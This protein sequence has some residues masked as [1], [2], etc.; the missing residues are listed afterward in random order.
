MII[1]TIAV[2]AQTPA[3]PA[4]SLPRKLTLAEAED[5]LIRRNLLV[6]AARYQIDANRAQ[7]LISSYKPNPVVT[8]GIEQLTFFSPAG[9]GLSRL[10]L[11]NA[12]AA[13]QPTYTF[14]VDKIWERGHKRELRVERAEFQL[15]AS[16]ARLLDTI[17]VQLFQLR[18]AFTNATLARENLALAE[19][20]ER[21]YEQ[22]ERLTQ[23]RVEAGDQAGMEI[24]RIRAGRLQFQQAVLQ[25]RASYEQAARDV[26][27]LLDAPPEALS[28]TQAAPELICHFDDRPVTQSRAE[29]RTMALEHRPD[30]AAARR[31]LEAAESETRLA[32][33][34]RARDVDVAYEYQRVGSDFAA[35]VIVQ[36]PL[37][38]YNDQ[39]AA[40]SQAE[41][42][43]ASAEAALRQAEAQAITEVEKAYQSYLT[44]R[45][46]LD[47][48]NNQNLEQI[49]KLRAIASY[50]YKAG[51]SSLIELLDAHR[52]YNQALT[53]YNQARADYQL[54]LWR[55]EEA[56]GHPLR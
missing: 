9:G 13:A 18:Q 6:I 26:L 11:T 2:G 55:L 38:V 34:G 5:L 46:T 24:Y 52:Y 47:L 49:E 7:R 10:F 40:I 3:P 54:S 50:S 19:T 39:R 28:P 32:R 15:K 51:A 42:Q 43:R 30:V 21:E 12:A 23:D 4:Q 14:R 53:A 29:L 27:L 16:E 33:A 17:R 35:G 37:F 8:V 36:F 31:A 25:A 44:A 1:S 45:R 20:I 22:T 48:Y 56:V 41:A